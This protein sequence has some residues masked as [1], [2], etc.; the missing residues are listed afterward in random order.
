MMVGHW[1]KNE[2][3]KEFVK[4]DM[5]KS[6]L[7]PDP[8]ELQNEIIRYIKQYRVKFIVPDGASVGVETLRRLYKRIRGS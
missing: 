7:S 6:W 3:N 4:V 2:D 1:H 5:V 8:D